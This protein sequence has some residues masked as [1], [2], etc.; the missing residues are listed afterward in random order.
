MTPLVVGRAGAHAAATALPS[1]RSSLP[2]VRWAATAPHGPIISF[3]GVKCREDP[4][5]LGRGLPEH[6][7]FEPPAVGALPLMRSRGAAEGG[8]HQAEQI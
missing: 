3:A 8:G 7:P 2:S 5:F 1:V 4:D 6:W